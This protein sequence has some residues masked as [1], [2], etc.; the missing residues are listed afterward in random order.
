QVIADFYRIADVLFLPSREE[1]FGIPVIEAAFSH[2]P[3]FC[4]DIPPLHELGLSDMT[5]FSPD[6]APAKIADMLGK[7]LQAS[8]PARLS[9]RIRS[10]FRW[11]SIYAKHVAPLLSKET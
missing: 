8:A 2:L 6:E 1:G 7:Y 5:Y 11:E 4:A 10:S 9:M 3:A